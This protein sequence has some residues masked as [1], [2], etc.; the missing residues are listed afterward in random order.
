MN[1]STH[2]QRA[3]IVQQDKVILF[4]SVQFVIHPVYL[5]LEAQIMTAHNVQATNFSL[6]TPV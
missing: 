1:A 4:K 6:I 2:V 5:A 3:I